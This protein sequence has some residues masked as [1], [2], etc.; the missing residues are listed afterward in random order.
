VVALDEGADAVKLGLTKPEEKDY[1]YMQ[2]VDPGE[3][4]THGG[5]VVFRCRRKKSDEVAL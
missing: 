4:Y 5:T 1:A 2:C 3:P